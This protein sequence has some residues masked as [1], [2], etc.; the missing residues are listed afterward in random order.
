MKKSKFKALVIAYRIIKSIVTALTFL[1]IG[2]A[3]C[4]WN[5][6]RIINDLHDKAH[7]EKKT[8]VWFAIRCIINYLA[9]VF[10]TLF[11]I[12]V[13]LYI[14]KMFSTSINFLPLK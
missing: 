13:L 6:K 10:L 8:S 2:G 3:L 11:N 7:K 1:L 14:W 4:C 5:W 12:F 9:V